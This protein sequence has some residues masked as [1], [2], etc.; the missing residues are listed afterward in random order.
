LF[1]F[2]FLQEHNLQIG[3]LNKMTSFDFFYF[4]S[5]ILAFVS[6]LKAVST[7]AVHLA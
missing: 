4:G 3:D 1:L 5:R 7:T 2:Y 6:Y